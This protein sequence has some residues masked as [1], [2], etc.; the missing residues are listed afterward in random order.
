MRLQIPQHGHVPVIGA[1]VRRIASKG[2]APIHV[3]LA[4]FDQPTHTLM[5]THPYGEVERCGAIL[6]AAVHVHTAFL[7]QP[8]AHGYV[9]VASR[10]VQRLPVSLAAAR[11][12]SR[13]HC[14]PLHEVATHG[15]MTVSRRPRQWG[16]AVMI[17]AL[18]G[19]PST[20]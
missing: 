12:L 2:I 13:V 14:T 16:V 15:E 10:P 4:H 5:V 8:S 11:A 3:T 9:A 19:I 1:P 17:P 7:H 18:E 20:R 6:G